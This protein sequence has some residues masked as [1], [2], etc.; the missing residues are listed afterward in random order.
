MIARALEEIARER[1]AATKRTA[2]ARERVLHSFSAAP[3]LAAIDAVYNEVRANH[4]CPESDGRE[5]W[6]DD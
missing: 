2:L 1:S 3:W 6:S 4:G 5:L